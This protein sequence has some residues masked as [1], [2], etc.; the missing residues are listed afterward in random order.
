[1]IEFALKFLNQIFHIFVEI[2][3]LRIFFPKSKKN[4]ICKQEIDLLG[5]KVFTRT[6][7]IV[8][9]SIFGGSF[10]VPSRTFASSLKMGIRTRG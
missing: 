5:P 10:H 3:I 4:K 2:S 7:D 9:V 8:Q 1:M 6:L